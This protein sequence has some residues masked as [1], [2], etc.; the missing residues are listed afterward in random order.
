M[1]QNLQWLLIIVN[2][3][4]IRKNETINEKLTTETL[5]LANRRRVQ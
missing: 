4:K 5:S 1:F 3:I 2:F